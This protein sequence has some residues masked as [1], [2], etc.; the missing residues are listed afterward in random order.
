MLRLAQQ[1]IE[2]KAKML[3]LDE[4]MNNLFEGDCI[5]LMGQF[6]DKCIDMALCDLTFGTR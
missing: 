5:E 3:S 2:K 4:I 1:I 6:L